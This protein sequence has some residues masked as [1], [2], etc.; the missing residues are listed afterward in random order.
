MIKDKDYYSNLDKDSSEYRA[1]H[2][3]NRLENND[4]SPIKWNC[5]DDI[6]SN[7]I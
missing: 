2:K 1:Y 3:F 5:D 6:D 7:K 4:K